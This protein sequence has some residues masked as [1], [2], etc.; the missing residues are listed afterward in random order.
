MVDKVQP[1]A[2]TSSPD[3][4][5][6]ASYVTPVSWLL[7]KAK[8]IIQPPSLPASMLGHPRGIAF[9]IAVMQSRFTH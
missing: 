2:G 6:A 4:R 1:A 8:I 5:V 9:S 3:P 7:K